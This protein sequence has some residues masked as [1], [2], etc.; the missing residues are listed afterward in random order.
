MHATKEQVHR[1]VHTI[2]GAYERGQ[3]CTAAFLDI[4]QA[5]DK[6]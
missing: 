6:V 3:Y 2:L 1:T 5:F 4:S